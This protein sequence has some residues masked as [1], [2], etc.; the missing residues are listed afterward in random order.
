M[1]IEKFSALCGLHEGY[2]MEELLTQDFLCEF[3]Q[4]LSRKLRQVLELRI[5]GKS[6]KTIARLM[7]TDERTVERQLYE[8]QRR[9]K[10]G[11]ID[12]VDNTQIMRDH[13]R[14]LPVPQTMKELRQY[15][16]N[17]KKWRQNYE[18]NHPNTQP[19]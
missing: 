11:M 15:N 3:Y 14:G 5:E 18:R 8:I 9:Y 4:I 7:R 12:R 16:K 2:W 10:S 19:S 1:N 13:K 17:P 6:N